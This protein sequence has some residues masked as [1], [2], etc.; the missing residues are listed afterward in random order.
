[1]TIQIKDLTGCQQIAM[2]AV[3][4][5]LIIHGDAGGF[6]VPCDAYINNVIMSAA[7]QGPVAIVA[8][9]AAL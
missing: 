7:A 1:M 2:R 9:A 5:G 4:G 8:A 3:R 6:S